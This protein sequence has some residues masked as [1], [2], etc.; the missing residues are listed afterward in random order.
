MYGSYEEG[1]LKLPHIESF[2]KA[3]KIIWIQKLNNP[4]DFSDWKILFLN[5]SEKI[6][7]GNLWVLEKSHLQHL[8]TKK[9]FNVF[10]KEILTTWSS[11]PDEPPSHAIEYLSQRLWYNSY[12]KIEN[13]P[14]YYHNWLN[15]GIECIKDL[16][17]AHGD[18][19]SVQEFQQLYG[20]DCNFLKFYGVISAIPITWK[21]A[22][23]NYKQ[24]IENPIISE[25]LLILKNGQKPTKPFYRIMVKAY[26]ETPTSQKKWNNAFPSIAVDDWKAF[27]SLPFRISNSAKIKIVQFKFLH[28]IIPTRRLLKKM[29]IADDTSCRFC[30]NAEETLSHAFFDCKITNTFLEKLSSE[31]SKSCSFIIPVDKKIIF[32]GM[33]PVNSNWAQ[34]NII[35]LL[36]NFLFSMLMQQKT[37]QIE[38]FK[39]YVEKIHSLEDAT[40][41]KYNKLWSPLFPFFDN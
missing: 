11:I 24:N 37:P 8:S 7:S 14:V 15:A 3:L 10:W 4:L 29:G 34:N 35:L 17:D 20:I 27:Y 19:I 40:R 31:L 2:I 33:T 26:I 32:F 41:K 30:N 13:R 9:T 28:R 22:I 39:K 1:G 18:F 36:K 23:K 6:Y 25:S 38:N 16:V 12:I 21:R 5:S